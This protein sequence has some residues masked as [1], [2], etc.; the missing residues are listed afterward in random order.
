MDKQ[1]QGNSI[2]K[3]LGHVE[4]IN[5]PEPKE[6]PNEENS[7]NESDKGGDKSE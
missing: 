6:K 3:S 1:K 4:L 2:E 5:T 7:A